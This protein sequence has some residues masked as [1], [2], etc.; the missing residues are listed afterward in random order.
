MANIAARAKVSKSVIAYHFG[1]KD[2]LFE[3]VLSA[4]FAAATD[5]VRPHL[6]AET[7]ARGQLRAYLEAR[8]GFLETHRSHMVAL[9]EIWTNLRDSDGRLRFGEADATQTVD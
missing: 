6:D 8:V 5:D 2:Q 3:E 4:V 9:F 1:S 7:T